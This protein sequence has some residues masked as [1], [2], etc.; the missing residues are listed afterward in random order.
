MNSEQEFAYYFDRFRKY[1]LVLSMVLIL[2]GNREHVAHASR[3]ICHIGEKNPTYD[4]SRSNQMPYTD[5]MTHFWVTIW[6]RYQWPLIHFCFDIT[7]HT[8]NDKVHKFY[9]E[10]GLSGFTVINPFRLADP[11]RLDP[12]PALDKKTQILYSTFRNITKIRNLRL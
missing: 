3:K 11:G 2:D 5:Q 10:D 7:R 9:E 6:F 12:D 1:V 8:R 4:C